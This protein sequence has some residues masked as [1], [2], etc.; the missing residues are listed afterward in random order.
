[1]SLSPSNEK[2]IV[3]S[4]IPATIPEK[5]SLRHL[6]AE[7][8]FMISSHLDQAKD[9]SALARTCKRFYGPLIEELYE[10]N[11]QHQDA[12]ALVWAVESDTRIDTLKRLHAY[13]ADVTSCSEIERVEVPCL[14]CGISLG[15]PCMP[16][17]ANSGLVHLAARSGQPKTV[18]WLLDHGVS[19]EV[20][21]VDDCPC[22]FRR[23]NDVTPFMTACLFGCLRTARALLDAGA[24]GLEL[25]PPYIHAAMESPVNCLRCDKERFFRPPAHRDVWLRV[26]PHH[27]RQ[28]MTPCPPVKHDQWETD[29]QHLISTLVVWGADTNAAAPRLIGPARC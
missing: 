25:F 29:R 9:K 13:G 12:D 26:L 2:T 23:A 7:L 21:A 1:M 28:Q 17:S 3:P 22:G 11:V 6:P 18:S 4:P 14:H 5:A 16:F 24:N 15:S 19:A 27:L 10:H 8:L 20:T